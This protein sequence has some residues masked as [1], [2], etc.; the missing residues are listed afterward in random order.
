MTDDLLLE[1]GTEELPPTQLKTLAA[2]LGEQ[3][4]AAFVK[5]GLAHGTVE[6]FASP[7]RLAVIVRA[8]ADAQ[9]SHEVER[10]GPALEAAFDQAGNPTPACLGFARSCGV[11]VDALEKRE[12]PKGIWLFYQQTQEGKSTRALLPDLI[13]QALKKLPIKRPMH[14]GVHPAPFIR[15]AHWVL[16]LYGKTVV[17]SAILGLSANNQT[18]GHRFHHPEA[19]TINHADEYTKKLAEVGQVIVDLDQRE[20]LIC[21]Q[22]VEVASKQGDVRIAP[23]LLEEV[24]GLVEKPVALLGSFDKAFLELPPEV[25]IAVMKKHQKCFPMQNKAGELAPYFVIISNIESKNPAEVIKGN[26]RVMHAR[27]ADAAFFYEKD[28][29]SSIE[30]W[31]KRLHEVAFLKELE[32]KGESGVMS[33]RCKR[34]EH[35]SKYVASQIEADEKAAGEAGRLSK[36]DMLSTMVEEFP[37]LMGVMGYHYALH[38]GLPNAVAT[39]IRSHHLP[40]FSGDVLPEDLVGCAVAIADRVDLL[41]AIFGINQAPT[42]EKDPFGARRAALGVLRILIEHELDLDIGELLEKALGEYTNAFPQR[43]EQQQPLQK[44]SDFMLDR[45]KAWSLERGIAPTV[46]AAVAAGGLSSPPDF[47]QRLQ[48]VTAF[49]C[50]PQ[51]V[52][53]TAAHKRVNQFLKKQSADEVSSNMDAQ[54]FETDAERDLASAIQAKAEIVKPLYKNR[55]YQAVLTTLA[56]LQGPID[57]F[58]DQVLVL[59]EDPTIRKN[60]IALL[61]QLRDLF[62]QIA[63]ISQL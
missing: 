31:F 37:D 29:K 44:L 48:A 58:F 23:D 2:A 45:L 39:A 9:P 62:L 14:W 32:K 10:R 42:G 11:E 41:V 33:G 35:L 27:L 16:L 56:D 63:D 51:A 59:A 22:S 34:I 24:V 43:K 1:I 54:L 25:L 53:L 36:A 3:L 52:S 12:T 17:P 21:N 4:R 38:L 49:Q 61:A 26:E 18:F 40:R 30:D 50:L 5:A 13:E 15:P 46:F 60:R 8:L 19:I 47:Y 28:K 6:T 20:R 57:A 7:R 55:D